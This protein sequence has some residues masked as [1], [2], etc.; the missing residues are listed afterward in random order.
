MTGI[1]CFG[2]KF[3]FNGNVAIRFGKNGLIVLNREKDV[4]W[5]SFFNGVISGKEEEAKFTDTVNVGAFKVMRQIERRL[6]PIIPIIRIMGI[7][8]IKFS[9]ACY[10]R[11]DLYLRTLTRRGRRWTEEEENV[12]SFAL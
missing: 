12:F 6:M 3:Y 2:F 4:F 5:M 8:R 10:R 7:K 1:L 9:P 11:K